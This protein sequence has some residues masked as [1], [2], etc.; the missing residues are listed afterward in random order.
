MNR[1]QIE[2]KLVSCDKAVID[3]MY[4]E[5]KVNDRLRQN[6]YEYFELIEKEV[7]RRKVMVNSIFDKR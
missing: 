1:K 6:N 7:E 2:D 4:H 5:L 3:D